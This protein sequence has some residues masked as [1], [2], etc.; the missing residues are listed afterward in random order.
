M[1]YIDVGTQLRYKYLILCFFK[2][3]QLES[4]P[5]V[6]FLYRLYEG[7][8]ISHCTK[9]TFGREKTDIEYRAQKGL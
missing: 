7:K 9:N 2:G 1:K 4:W 3:S 8:L 6:G 5:F